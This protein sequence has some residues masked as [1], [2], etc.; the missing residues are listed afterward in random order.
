VSTAAAWWQLP[1]YRQQRQA[2]GSGCG[3]A[4]SSQEV[5]AAA[6]NGRVVDSG[7]QIVAAATALTAAAS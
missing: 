6:I 4:S 3:A 5:A 2:S 1:R 7:I